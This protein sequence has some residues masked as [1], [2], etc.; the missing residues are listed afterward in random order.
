MTAPNHA[1]VLTSNK[2]AAM[3]SMTPTE[4]LPHGSMPTVVK[5]YTDSGEPVNLKYNVCNRMIAA[6]NRAA[7]NRIGDFAISWSVD[8]G[9]KVSARVVGKRRVVD[10]LAT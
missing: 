8:L 10:N 2:N 6:I 5:I 4:I 3:S 7:T 9:L 1:V